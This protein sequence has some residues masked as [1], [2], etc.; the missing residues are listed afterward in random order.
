M[1]YYQLTLQ[2][3]LT[4]RQKEATRHQG[5]IVVAFELQENEKEIH[6]TPER[7]ARHIAAIKLLQATERTRTAQ[8][9]TTSPWGDSRLSE[10]TPVLPKEL[11]FLSEVTEEGVYDL[12]GNKVG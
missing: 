10:A 5:P 7:K 1:E 8:K 9:V 11:G 12:D 3:N 2:P 6:P 4:D